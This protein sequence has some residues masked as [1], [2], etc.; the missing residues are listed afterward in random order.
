MEMLMTEKSLI[1]V[2]NSQKKMIYR[3][4]DKKEAAALK[5]NAYTSSLD[6]TMLN[7]DSLK[8]HGVENHF[9]HYTIYTSKKIINKTELYINEH[10]G[11]IERL[12]Y[13]YN[14]NLYKD[15][16]KVEVHFKQLHQGNEKN[17]EVSEQK[18]I[19]RID[20]K[21]QKSLQ[22]SNFDLSIISNG[23]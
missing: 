22:Y 15:I 11:M 20:K 8:Y 12:T 14:P 6:S 5:R 4:I 13:F 16:Y 23:N 21:I 10:S 17:E 1:M 7:Y 9:K 18:F 3:D 19:T 2:Y